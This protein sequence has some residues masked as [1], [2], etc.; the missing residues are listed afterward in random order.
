MNE[1]PLNNSIFWVDVDKIRSN[2]YQ[3]R[4][5]FDEDKLNDLADSIRQYGILQPLVVTRHE[6]E[7]VDGGLQAYYELIAGERRLRSAKL[8]G[9]SQVPVMIRDGGSTEEHARLKLELAII[10]NV[11]REDLN[12][13]ERA[14]AFKRLAE[15]FGFKHAE[16]A[17]KIGKSREFVANSIR[18][19]A[20]PEDVVEALAKNKITEG[21]TRPLLMI[22]NG[23]PE[24]QR[25]LF[26]NIVQ[27]NISVREAER[28]ARHIAQEKAHK[29]S[30]KVI[31]PEYRDLENELTERLGTRVQVE[32]RSM[33]GRVIID[34]FSE[35][36]LGKLLG[37]VGVRDNTVI[38]TVR[39]STSDISPMPNTTLIE[40]HNKEKKEDDQE[41]YSIKNF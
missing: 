31:P 9:V 19:L 28:I 38:N 34:F 37:R 25:A 11:Q 18:I 14:R 6:E 20:L 33:G 23:R 8:A 1:H 13:V 4:T 15:E 12:P 32:Q 16:I 41:L 21:H 10:E 2:P 7:R 5:Y 22:G 40:D 29:R 27:K 39:A 24:A 30:R 35:E 17:K 36:D 26:N 3:P